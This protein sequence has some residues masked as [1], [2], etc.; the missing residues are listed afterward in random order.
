MSLKTKADHGSLC[1]EVAMKI[2]VSSVCDIGIE[3]TNNEDAVGIC[4]DLK[5]H[6]WNQN[7]TNGYIPLPTEGAIFVVAD[8]MGGANA[9]EIASKLAIQ[10]IEDSL[11]EDGSIMQNTTKES[12]HSFLRRSIVKSNQTILEYVTH[13]PDSMGLGTTIVLAWILNEYAYI[14]WCGDSRCYCFNP[15][16]GLQLLTKDHSLVQELIDRGEIKREEAFNHPDNNVIT[17]CLGDVDAE[18]EP[19]FLTYK[20]CDGDIFFALF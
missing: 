18:P 20:I 9:G 5:N 4:F 6:L 12:I 8:G 15:N 10:S 16:T 14:A 2:N 7:S 13:S 19:E 11:G 17:R 1:N 3:R